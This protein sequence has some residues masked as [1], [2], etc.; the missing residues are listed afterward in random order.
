MSKFYDDIKTG[1]EE[2][3]EISKKDIPKD[4]TYCTN[5]NCTRNCERNI[6]NHDFSKH[7][8]TISNFHEAENFKE[9]NCRYYLLKK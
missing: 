7:I 1:L 5:K 4:I 8:I 2:A 3:I 6:N 9:E